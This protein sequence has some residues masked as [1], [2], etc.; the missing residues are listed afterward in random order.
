MTS[1]QAFYFC[2]TL[3]QWTTAQGKIMSNK[4]KEHQFNIATNHA[5]FQQMYDGFGSFLHPKQL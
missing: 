5:I 4:N 3:S 2:L 1:E